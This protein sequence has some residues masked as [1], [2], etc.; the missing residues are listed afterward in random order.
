MDLEIIV[1]SEVSQRDGEIL[2]GIPYVQSVER[3]AYKRICL[4]N[5]NRLR[6]Q[7]YGC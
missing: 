5:R 6:E 4:Q 2:Y 7:T 1:L 3:N